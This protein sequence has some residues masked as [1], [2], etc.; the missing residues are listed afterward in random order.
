MNNNNKNYIIQQIDHLKHDI[1]QLIDNKKNADTKVLITK[2]EDEKRIKMDQLKRLT[3]QL[4]I[5]HKKEREDKQRKTDL[6]SVGK[7]L[8]NLEFRHAKKKNTNIA[9]TQAKRAKEIRQEAHQKYLDYLKL[10][11]LYFQND[12]KALPGILF[13]HQSII[14]EYGVCPN[15]AFELNITDEDTVDNVVVENNV[16]ENNV[17]ENNVVEN[18]V[19][20][21]V[22]NK[23]DIIYNKRLEWLSGQ[24][25]NGVLYYNLY[26]T[27][28]NKKELNLVSNERCES[29]KKISDFIKLILTDG[30]YELWEKCLDFINEYVQCNIKTKRL[31][32][33]F[34]IFIHNLS[35]L[36]SETNIKFHDFLSN[37]FN[38][39]IDVNIIN[40]EA[41]NVPETII[42][43]D[44]FDEYV[45]E[46][47][48]QSEI[49]KTKEKFIVN[50]IKNLKQDLCI[51]LTDNTQ[52]INVHIDNNVQSNKC[53]YSQVGKY[54]KRWTILKQDERL[55]RFESFSLFYVQKFLIDQGII[56][57]SEKDNVSMTLSELLKLA[58]G[59]K[60]M[61]YR[62]FVWNTTRGI[63]ETVKILNYDKE[64][65]FVLKYTKQQPQKLDNNEPTNVKKKVST[66]SIITKESEKIINEDLLYFIVKRIQSGTV[67][68]EDKEAFAERIKMK[69]KIKKLTVNDKMKIFEKYDE[70]FEVVKNNKQ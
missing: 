47:Q 29:E 50:T 11:K 43:S 22:E 24:K 9:L 45:K 12:P 30:Q 70:I 41:R 25:D 68:K 55:E 23:T 33:K 65:G 54:F 19:K 63:I 59:S 3:E 6:I 38:C 28:I 51:F 17:V 34:K 52:F 1:Q 5:I 16:V 21:A 32:E 20:E 40:L 67:S 2:Y 4:K 48:N 44:Q 31:K 61:V 37:K 42:L 58:Y 56:D 64:L 69:L 8:D 66:R 62:D 26:D 53:K 15:I 39:I 13:L 57:I 27:L 18:A 60:K 46:F 10:E 14:K 7:V 36:Y 35:I 49:I